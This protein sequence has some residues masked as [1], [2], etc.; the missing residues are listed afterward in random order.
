MAHEFRT[1]LSLI[2]GPAEKLANNTSI[3]EAGRNFVK[4]IENNARRLLWLNNQLLDFRKIENKSMKLRVSEFDIVNFTRSIYSIFADK[5]ERKQISYS[6][7]TDLDRL[8]VK[9][10]LRKVETILFN[11]LSNAFKF[12]PEKGSIS[13]KIQITDN[14]AESDLSISVKDSGIGIPEEYHKEVF[15][16]FFQTK[17]SVSLERGTG[18]GLTLVDEYVRMHCG[19]IELDS[20]PGKGSDFQVLLPLNF[21]YPS[22]IT[23][24]TDPDTTG[25]IIKSENTK[26][27]TSTP[28]A[29]SAGSPYILLIEDDKEISDFIFMSLKEKYHME[30]ASNGKIALQTISKKPPSLVISDI[31]MPEMDG[32]A[33]TKKFK[34]NPKTSHIPLILL[35]GQSQMEDQLEGLKSGADAYIVKP[36]AI[37][38]LEVRIENFL[39]R[40]EQLTEF[41]I[42][43]D[44]SKPRELQI[45][46][47]DEKMLE[48]VVAC[49]EK[50]MSDPELRISKV[51][52]HTG[53]SHPF[54]YRKIKSLTGQTT[55][56]FIR[57]VRVQRAEQ[58][59]RTK[60]FTVAEVMNETGFTNHS[61]FSKCFRKI[62]QTSPKEYIQ[63]A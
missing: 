36:F 4:L 63:K 23:I 20:Q 38:L 30:L 60:R 51:S 11:L 18:I 54:L 3:N 16:R 59:L 1:P 21:N 44:I 29:A 9:M 35:S 37:E 17:E 62:Y 42:H 19:R 48:K 40:R 13:V 14:D 26:E 53:F 55:N 52:K 8:D 41:L 58:L 10:D 32:I 6:F 5:A 15:K 27:M 31:K 43:N 22:E 24:V 2:I 46:S 12:T 45:T 57:T 25:P 28:L 34:S 50:Y 33:F 49:I 56:E 39:K 7:E 47:Q 61:Y